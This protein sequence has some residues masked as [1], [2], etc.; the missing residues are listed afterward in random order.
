[1]NVAPL[2][3]SQLRK[4]V[5]EIFKRNGITPAVAADELDQLV[6]QVQELSSALSNMQSSFERLGIGTEELGAGEVEV[7]FLIPRQ[8]V[9]D[10]L[11]ALGLES[12]T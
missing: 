2:L 4:R 9:H 7:G 12:S 3:G 1:M 10:G 6:Q 5:D 8:E 11:E